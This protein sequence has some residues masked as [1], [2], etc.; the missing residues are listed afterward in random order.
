M[1]ILIADDEKDVR[2]LVRFTFERRG[3][4][5]VEAT[6]GIEAVTLARRELPALILLDAM[7]PG[8]SGYEASRELKKAEAT[9]EIPIVFL[10]AKGQ[11]YEVI[12]G[13]EAGAVAYIIKPFSPK[14]LVGQVEEILQKHQR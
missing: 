10:S 3:F 9:K 5:V 1:K 7:M 12:E 11:T 4:E 13:L 2:D 6:D 14:E 8:M